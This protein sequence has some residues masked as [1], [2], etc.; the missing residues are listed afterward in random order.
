[1]LVR[2]LLAV[3]AGLLSLLI[4]IVPAT[5]GI[6][7]IPCTGEKIVRLQDLAGMPPATTGSPVGLGYLYTG[8]FS[9]RWI[10]HTGSDSQYID[11]GSILL[12]FATAANGGREPSE[13][14]LAWGMWNYPVAF[15]VEWL[16]AGLLALIVG[17]G[18][19]N[20]ALYG[21]FA[22]PSSGIQTPAAVAG[23]APRQPKGF[24]R[25]V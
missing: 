10:G 21:T 20:F 19:R 25:R 11:A 15:W 14:G 22:H 13:P 17:G 16:W 3:F 12:T 24:G 4:T 5:A 1:M 8:C 9:G 6:V 18:L 23:P 2:S 7:P